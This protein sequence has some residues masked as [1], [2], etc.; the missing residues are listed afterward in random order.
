MIQI[1]DVRGD[2]N[3]AASPSVGIFWGVKQSGEL[4]LICE[5][6][7]LAESETY[8]DFLTFPTGHHEVWEP[9]TTMSASRL[10]QLKLPAS[11]AGREYEE[12]PRGR[13]VY[14]VPDKLF[15]IYA[16]RRLQTPQIIEAIRRAFHLADAVCNVRSDPHYR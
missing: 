5:K 14:H 15:T 9:L 6:A 2:D 11:I 16:D 4:F 12:F 13:V 10:K 3:I 7:T 8:G 1:R